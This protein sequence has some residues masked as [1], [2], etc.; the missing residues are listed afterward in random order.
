MKNKF[1]FLEVFDIFLIFLILKMYLQYC[2][3]LKWTRKNIITILLVLIWFAIPLLAKDVFNLSSQTTYFFYGLLIFFVISY[4]MMR[5]F[6]L[7]DTK[8]NVLYFELRW[9]LHIKKTLK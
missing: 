9:L 2:Q 5:A 6:V 3:F 1:T 8:L 4:W 7:K